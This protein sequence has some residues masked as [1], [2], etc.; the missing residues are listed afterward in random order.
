MSLNIVELSDRM[1]AEYLNLGSFLF[2]RLA[3]ER[4]KALQASLLIRGDVA[5][6]EVTLF[7]LFLLAS[8]A[9]L[10][11]CE[12]TLQ[13]KIKS[14]RNVHKTEDLSH[15]TTVNLGLSVVQCRHSWEVIT[16]SCAKSCEPAVWEHW[17]HLYTC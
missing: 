2:S 7:F 12:K 11:H 16:L 3:A 17:G 14:I 9:A 8:A 6:K 10:I 15:G 1:R 13:R 4:L 5:V